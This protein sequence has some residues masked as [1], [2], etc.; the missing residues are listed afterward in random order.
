MINIKYK[1]DSNTKD[2]LAEAI[3][4]EIQ[5]I[6]LDRSMVEFG[7]GATESTFLILSLGKLGYIRLN[8]AWFECQESGEDYYQLILAPTEFDDDFIWSLF[9][10][11][12][13]SKIK[14]IDILK[15]QIN[16]D[17]LTITF[18]FGILITRYDGK[19]VLIT[20]GEPAL[21]NITIIDNQTL[22]DEKINESQLSSI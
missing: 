10:F 6:Y 8:S 20:G 16:E 1:V 3:D 12:N 14:K 7:K 18:D 17:D 15:R 5:L 22:I 9:S 11:G 21:R 13:R 4:D 2:I 19:R